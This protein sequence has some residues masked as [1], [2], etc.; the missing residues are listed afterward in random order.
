VGRLEGL[1]GPAPN[2]VCG[3]QER[4]S[5]LHGW[6]IPKTPQSHFR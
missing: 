1:M 4:L 6:R 5:N 2:H 3:S